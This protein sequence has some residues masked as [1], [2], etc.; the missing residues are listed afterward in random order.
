MAHSHALQHTVG[1]VG[2]WKASAVTLAVDY[3]NVERK[4]EMKKVK[5]GERK[6][7]HGQVWQPNH[8][9]EHVLH[10]ARA[11]TGTFISKIFTGHD[12]PRS[13]HCTHVSTSARMCIL[14]NV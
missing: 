6:S 2:W 3:F 7:V 11:P 9:E 14:S 4:K 12:H 8:E 5:K 10:M 13:L 1:R